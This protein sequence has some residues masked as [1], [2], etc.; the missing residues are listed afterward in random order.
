MTP[1]LGSVAVVALRVALDAVDSALAAARRVTLPLQH[2]AI[3][4]SAAL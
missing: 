1:Q 4:A 3:Q 2:T